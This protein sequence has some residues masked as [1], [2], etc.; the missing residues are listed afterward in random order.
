L[1][2][3]R[4]DGTSRNIV[5]LSYFMLCPAHI[6]MHYLTF[7]RINFYNSIAE[8]LLKYIAHYIMFY[9]CLFTW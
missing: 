3:K 1:Y 7:L 4:K 6:S 8:R 2:L 5:Y 9:V